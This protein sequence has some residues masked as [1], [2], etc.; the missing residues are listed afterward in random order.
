MGQIKVRGLDEWIVGV[1]RDM[2]AEAG[3]SLEQHL[4]DV[5]RELVLES[6]RRFA[7]EAA[8]HLDEARRARGVL[9]S[10]VDIIREQREST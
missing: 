4:R 9:A 2:A 3:Q 10:S 6:Q 5:L 7:T 8:E 1:H